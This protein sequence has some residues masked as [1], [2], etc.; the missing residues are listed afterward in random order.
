MWHH[1]K[2]ILD[3]PADRDL[4]LAVI[5]AKGVHALVFAC[6]RDGCHWKDALTGQLVNVLPTHWQDW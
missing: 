4:R 3:V 1:I 5:D 6:R 2:D